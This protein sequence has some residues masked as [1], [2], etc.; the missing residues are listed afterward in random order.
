MVGLPC[1]VTGRVTARG[2][3]CRVLMLHQRAG[4]RPV[5]LRRLLV[6]CSNQRTILS[7]REAG[8]ATA[9]ASSRWP[10]LWRRWGRL[11]VLTSSGGMILSWTKTRSTKRLTARETSRRDLKVS[12]EA[13][14]PTMRWKISG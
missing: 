1:S 3:A 6:D 13:V 10:P 7:P 11:G 2:E 14:A 8:G 9:N 5:G 4:R 12:R